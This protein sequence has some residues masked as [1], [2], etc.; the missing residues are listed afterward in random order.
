MRVQDAVKRRCQ[1]DAAEAQIYVLHESQEARHP[2]RIARMTPSGARNPSRPHPA[3]EFSHAY[4]SRR[5]GRQERNLPGL[6]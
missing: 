4:V 3:G 1:T 6:F 2:N 5:K